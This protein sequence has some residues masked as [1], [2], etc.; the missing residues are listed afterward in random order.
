MNDVINRWNQTAALFSSRLQ[1]IQPHQWDAATPCS[2]WN[3]RQLVDHAVGVQARFGG[4]LGMQAEGADWD[5]VHSAFSNYLR[6]S[7]SLDGN[8]DVPGLG[9]MSK[10]QILEICTND[11]LI[12]T[13][14][15]ARAVG[16]DETLPEP[17]ASACFTWLQ[18]LPEAM[19]RSGRY[20]RAQRVGPEAGLQAQMLAFAGRQP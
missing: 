7:D 12:H 17:L 11:L 3:V 9:Q 19:L 13:W 10:A 6:S 14:D 18:S 1:A 8:V 5:K 16:A 2:E 20:S 15:V 4:M